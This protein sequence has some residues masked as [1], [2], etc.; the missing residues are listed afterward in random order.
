MSLAET[1]VPVAES[2]EDAYLQ[3]Q[4]PSSNGLDAFAMHEG[5][6]KEIDDIRKWYAV[7]AESAALAARLYYSGYGYSG[8]PLRCCGVSERLKA[9]LSEYD[10]GYKKLR[11]WIGWLKGREAWLQS[12]SD[13]VWKTKSDADL[14]RVVSEQAQ[15]DLQLAN[16]L[17]R[18]FLL[19]EDLVS[20]VG[21]IRIYS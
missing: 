3:Q 17:E 6:P 20:L 14:Y 11:E 5:C 9:G 15:D 2:A 1:Q 18:I 4:K 16:P 12:N 13:T 8:G 19:G 21:L 7:F 10:P